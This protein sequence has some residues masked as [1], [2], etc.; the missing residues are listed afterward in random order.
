MSDDPVY[1]VWS[2]EHRAWWGPEHRGY[3]RG[4]SQAGRY[5]R[6]EALE[7]CRQALGTAGHLGTLAELPVRLGDVIAFLAGAMF[8]GDLA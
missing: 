3:V 1:L 5:S 2:N 8:P 7:I 4:V 6:D